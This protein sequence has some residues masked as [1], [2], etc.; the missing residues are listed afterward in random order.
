MKDNKFFNYTQI[1]TNKTRETRV[2]A[3]GNYVIKTPNTT[4][5]SYIKNWLDKQS[6]AK[7]AVDDLC[8]IGNCGKFYFVPKITELSENDTPYVHEERVVGTPVTLD[9][10][11]ALTP[12]QQDKIFDALTNF[13]VDM[14][15]SRPVYD[16]ISLL[17][18][19]D[20]KGFTFANVLSE[21]QISKENKL[22]VQNAYDFLKSHQEMLASYV[23]FH[24]D[25]NEHN[26]FYDPEHNSVSFIDFAEAGYENAEYMFDHDLV[27]LPWFDMNKVKSKYNKTPA[28]QKVRTTS[29]PDMK[30]LFNAL[31]SFQW[32]GETLLTTKTK[33]GVSYIYNMLLDNMSE[34]N[35]CYKIC[36]Q[37]IQA[38]N[39]VFNNVRD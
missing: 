3:D 9:F 25:M 38:K 7:H 35:R 39:I 20:S 16:L 18:K 32:T 6:N 31:R 12:V 26:I 19:P 34:I 8:K 11:N 14:N 13:L 10:F 29:D 24:G 23:F 15:Q 28:H 27:K 37:K 2:F 36:L 17:E 21:L 33:T 5:P 1:N 22:N 4:N 30:K